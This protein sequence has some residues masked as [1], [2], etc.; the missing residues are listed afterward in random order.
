MTLVPNTIEALPLFQAWQHKVLQ[1]LFYLA[2]ATT[3]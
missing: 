3:L 2:L 1:M